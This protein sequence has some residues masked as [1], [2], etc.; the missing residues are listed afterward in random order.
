MTAPG[1]H[2]HPLGFV[3]DERTKVLAYSAA[4]LFIHPAP[5]DNLP[6]V[7]LES[8]ACGTPVAAF[9]IGGVPD[10]VRPGQTGWLADEAS[11]SALARAIDQ[12]LEELADG[13]DLRSICRDIA[14][15]EYAETFQVDAY[16]KLFQQLAQTG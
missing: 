15:R 16:L 13:L 12:A 1:V 5:V 14:E 6:N 8:L 9:P 2:L 3:E 7:I 11:P 4:D 10:M